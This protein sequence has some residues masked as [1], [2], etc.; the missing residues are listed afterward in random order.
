MISQRATTG[1][2][3]TMTVIPKNFAIQKT[4][5]LEKRAMAT[6]TAKLRS[7]T[8]TGNLKRVT[9]RVWICGISWLRM[10]GKIVIVISMTKG[11]LMMRITARETAAM[12]KKMS[13]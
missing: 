11:F 12:A 9:M 5:G 4:S 1:T 7:S 10:T 6:A 13:T 2:L 8:A 3:K